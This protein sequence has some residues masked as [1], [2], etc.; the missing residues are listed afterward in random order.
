[1]R[2]HVFHL[3]VACAI[4]IA[5][6]AGYSLW[7]VAVA[8]KSADVAGLQNQ[9][10]AKTETASRIASARAV[11]ADV[12]G[13]EAAVQS[14]FVPETGVVAFISGLEARGRAQG[15]AVS[16]LSVSTTQGARPTLLFALT[17]KGTFDAVMRT[18]GVI[19]YAPH[20]ISFSGLSLVQNEEGDWQAD[21]KLV[22]GSV[23]ASARTP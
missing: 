12:A 9:I 6:L 21:L 4:S 22:V 16:V 13:A 17:I 3:I 8:K 7:Y 2:S 18:V 10:D 14:Y 5:A 15:A 19:E 20:D 11:L 1:M 23:G